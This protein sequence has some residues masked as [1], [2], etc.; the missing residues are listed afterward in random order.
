[1]TRPAE[2]AGAAGSIALLIAYTL[3]VNDAQ[4]I[5]VLGAALGLI[6][7]AVTGLVAGGGITGTAKRI[8]RG[9]T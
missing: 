7:A 6:P 8:W 1:M 2:T 3:G 4:L 5:T 9:R